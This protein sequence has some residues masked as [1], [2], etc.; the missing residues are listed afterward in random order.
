MCCDCVMFGQSNWFTWSHRIGLCENPKWGLHLTCFKAMV[1]SHHMWRWLQLG[2]Q[3]VGILCRNLFSAM[4]ACE[5]A[6]VELLGLTGH[7]D[8]EKG[9]L[10]SCDG[11]RLASKVKDGVINGSPL[12]F[13]HCCGECKSKRKW[14]LAFCSYQR[15]TEV[16]GVVGQLTGT[17]TPYSL[18]WQWQLWNHF[19]G[20]VL[21]WLLSLALVQTL[22]S[23]L[24]YYNYNLL[25]L[26]QATLTVD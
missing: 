2:N 1:V 6:D 9:K 26:T 16:I 21:L 15:E 11:C 20:D 7:D 5:Q 24:R 8:K 23:S 22:A 25:M 18:L 13:V 19:V 4:L 17:I 10:H 12:G 3:W 14:F